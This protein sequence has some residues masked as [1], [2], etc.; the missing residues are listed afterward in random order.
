MNLTT[1]ATQLNAHLHR[2]ETQYPKRYYHAGALLIGRH[3]EAWT[4]S[5]QHA[6]KMT[7]AEASA[8]LGTL[9]REVA[10]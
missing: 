7:K 6:Q 10:R 9:T 1:L 3:I 4:H 2:L 5:Y 8:Y